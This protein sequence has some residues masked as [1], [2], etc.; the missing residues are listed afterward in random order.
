MSDSFPFKWRRLE[1]DIILCAE[2]WNLRYALS[3]RDEDSH[4]T[5]ST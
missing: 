3:Y 4:L 5:I 2:R 1:A